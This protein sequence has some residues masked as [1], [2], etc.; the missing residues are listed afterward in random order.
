MAPTEPRSGEVVDN[1]LRWRGASAERRVGGTPSTPL[2]SEP[3]SGDVVRTT[4]PPLYPPAKPH[5]DNIA[6]PQL[7]LFLVSPIPRLPAVG[8]GYPQHRRSAA[9]SEVH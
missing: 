6:A 3:Q 4:L 2:N 5:K 9:Y 8:A 1:P 7:I